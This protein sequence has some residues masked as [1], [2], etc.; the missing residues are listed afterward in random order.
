MSRVHKTL[1]LLLAAVLCLPLAYAVVTERRP[2]WLSWRMHEF[3]RINELFTRPARQWP[4]HEV[5]LENAHGERFAVRPDPV[6]RHRLYG[7]MTRLDRLLLVLDS[8]GEETP[9][10]DLI[11][12]R[13]GRRYADHYPGT[14]AV[15]FRRV[16]IPSRR[17]AAAIRPWV[18]PA[19]DIP[20]ITLHTCD[21][22]GE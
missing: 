14:T 11:Y 13:L 21:T 7:A 17:D 12:E 8:V 10:R 4:R 22:G 16:W 18:H 1:A 9:E 2:P 6:F 5:V 3:W 20:A 15:H 19:P